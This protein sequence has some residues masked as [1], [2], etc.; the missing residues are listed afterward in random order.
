LSCLGFGP[1]I[2]IAHFVGQPGQS[3]T[4]VFEQRPLL[5]FLA[6]GQVDGIAVFAFGFDQ[7]VQLLPALL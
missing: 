5:F 1:H 3:G 7:I 4:D 6:G 2:V